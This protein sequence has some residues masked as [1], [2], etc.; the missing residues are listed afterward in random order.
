M[1]YQLTYADTA[2]VGAG[3][4]TEVKARMLGELYVRS[5]A[6][7]SGGP[8]EEAPRGVSV[9]AFRDRVR[10]QLARE[11]SLPIEAIHEHTA[12]MPAAYL[13]NTS[14]EDMV[15]HIAMIARVRST[16]QPVIESRTEFGS[17]YT[18]LTIVTYDDPKP[19]LL[20]K[21]C[22]V[23]YAHDVN[24]HAAQVFTRSSSDRVAIDTVWVDFRDKPLSPQKRGELEEAFRQV[25][26]RQTTVAQLLERRGK[27]TEIVQPVRS[28]RLDDQSSGSY[29]ILDVLVPDSRGVAYRLSAV[30]SA[31]GWNIHSARL[32]TWGGNARTAFYV[33]DTLGHKVPSEALERLRE[34]L[35]QEEPRPRRRPTRTGAASTAR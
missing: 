23:L 6:V 10:R 2:A 34:L 20:A 30:L 13:L 12:A 7:L 3:M 17:D 31:M 22:G 26:T 4:W 28:L 35:P 8:G 11:K 9:Q 16:H 25:L 15:L 1:L 18:E 24:A 19:G 21:I 27:T 14:V 29:S 32:S 5:E 33:T